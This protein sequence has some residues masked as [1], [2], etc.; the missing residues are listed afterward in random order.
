MINELAQRFF[1]RGGGLR[2]RSAITHFA[3]VG[4]QVVELPFV[5]SV[6]VRE[7]VC[8]RDDRF[9]AQGGGIIRALN[10]N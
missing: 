4:D 7:F 8:V 6:I 1:A 9:Q 3:R 5:A 2:V 10:Q